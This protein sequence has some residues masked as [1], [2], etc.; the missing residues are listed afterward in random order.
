M[1]ARQ[2]EYQWFDGRHYRAAVDIKAYREQMGMLRHDLLNS[3]NTLNIADAALLDNEYLNWLLDHRQRCRKQDQ[4]RH[5]ATAL[6]DQV[7]L[8]IG[9]YF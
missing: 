8:H 9:T 2:A 7:G 4:Y 6:C 5:N 1:D 3:F